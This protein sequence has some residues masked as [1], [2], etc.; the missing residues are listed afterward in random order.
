MTELLLL[1]LSNLSQCL[2][3]QSLDLTVKIRC[4][5]TGS[6]FVSLPPFLFLTSVRHTKVRI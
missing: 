2:Q 4:L 1:V 6:V 3:L 5:H